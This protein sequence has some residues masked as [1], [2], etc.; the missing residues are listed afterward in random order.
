MELYIN[1]F[2]RRQT[3]DSCYSHWDLS[4]DEF[5]QRIRDGFDSAKKGYREGVL[6]VPVA[7]DG[8]YTGV[9]QLK[10][11]DKLVGD[12]SPRKELEEP[13]QHI[14][15]V[16]G[17]KQP[18]VAVDIILYSHAVLEETGENQ[19]FA[20][21]EVI[22]VNA[23][24]TEEEQPIHPMTLLANHFQADGGTATNMSAEEL[25]AT[26][27]VGFEYWKDKALIQPKGN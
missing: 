8:F 9:V 6:L 20:D 12:F 17:E 1:S 24:T 7:P 14:Y 13:R 19:T 2:V 18:A 16:E 5:V 21:Y 22:S 27:K 10:D 4:D 15:A 25:E 3:P 23:R 26:L 11:G